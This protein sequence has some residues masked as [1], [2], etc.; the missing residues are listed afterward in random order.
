[1]GRKNIIHYGD[2]ARHVCATIVPWKR[3]LTMSGDWGV[4]NCQRCHREKLRH[5]ERELLKFE[6]EKKICVN[7]ELN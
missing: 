7:G 4:V 3:Q 6:L 1:M 5:D 2:G